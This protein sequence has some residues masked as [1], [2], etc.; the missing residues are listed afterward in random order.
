[1][2]TT[3]YLKNGVVQNSIRRIKENFGNKINIISDV[4]ICQYNISGHCGLFNKRDIQ[5]TN[6]TG[7]KP[8]IKIDND[9]TLKILGKIALSLV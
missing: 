3:S 4:C 6:I 1:M 9:K 5:N 8:N 2:G 7:K